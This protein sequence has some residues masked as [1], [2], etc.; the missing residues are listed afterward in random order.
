MTFTWAMYY[1]MR[2]H[3]FAWFFSQNKSS[4]M[5]DFT[6]IEPDP[7][8][9]HW[10]WSDFGRPSQHIWYHKVADYPHVAK[11]LMAMVHLLLKAGGKWQHDR[12]WPV[13]LEVGHSQK[14]TY[15]SKNK[16][17]N[18]INMRIVSCERDHPKTKAEYF[19]NHSVEKFRRYACLGLI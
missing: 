18:V 3:L 1:N 19:S 11:S 4:H 16:N 13:K 14:A 5:S 12:P 2:Q 6:C 17:R 8:R 10:G 9:P 15:L 7:E